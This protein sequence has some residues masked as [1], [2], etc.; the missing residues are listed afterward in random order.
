MAL[1][2]E[3]FDANASAQRYTPSGLYQTQISQ[4][5]LRLAI[6]PSTNQPFINGDAQVKTNLTDGAATINYCTLVPSG[7]NQPWNIQLNLFSGSNATQ[8]GWGYTPFTTGISWYFPGINP[9]QWFTPADKY[10]NIIAPEFVE[11]TNQGDNI[12]ALN[13]AT[14]DAGSA[15]YPFAGTTNANIVTVTPMLDMGFNNVTGSLGAWALADNTSDGGAAALTRTTV[16]PAEGTAMANIT[17]TWITGANGTGAYIGVIYTGNSFNGPINALNSIK[18]AVRNNNN[19]TT[20]PK[21]IVLQGT[22]STLSNY[23]VIG[24]GTITN[25]G[26]FHD[27]TVT[28]SP[29]SSDT[30]HG[31]IIAFYDT[32]SNVGKAWNI[33]VDDL[34]LNFKFAQLYNFAILKNSNYLLGNSKISALVT[35]NIAMKMYGHFDRLQNNYGGDWNFLA[36]K[37]Y[38]QFSVPTYPY[39]F[40]SS[41]ISGYYAAVLQYSWPTGGATFFGNT[42]PTSFTITNF[43]GSP[44]W[45]LNPTGQ[46]FALNRTDVT[47]NTYNWWKAS[48]TVV[49][50][51][52]FLSLIQSGFSYYSAPSIPTIQ[53]GFTSAYD[54]KFSFVSRP[55]VFNNKFNTSA[56]YK[57]GSNIIYQSS[58][59]KPYTMFT[60]QYSQIPIF[61]DNNVTGALPSLNICAISGGLQR[62]NVT[63]TGTLGSPAL[64]D[65]GV[66]TVIGGNSSTPIT[67]YISWDGSVGT[68]PLK[69][70]LKANSGGT[71]KTIDTG[72]WQDSVD[73][74]ID[75]TNTFTHVVGIKASGFNGQFLYYQMSGTTLLVSGEIINGA[76]LAG[77]PKPKIL[78]NPDGKVVVVTNQFMFRSGTNVWTQITGNTTTPLMVHA[79]HDVNYNWFVASNELTRFNQFI[80]TNGTLTP[81]V[82][83]SSAFSTTGQVSEYGAISGT[84]PDLPYVYY[85]GTNVII[86][87]NFEATAI[88]TQVFTQHGNTTGSVSSLDSVSGTRS[89]KIVTPAVTPTTGDYIQLNSS[90]G[91]KFISWVRIIQGQAYLA[92]GFYAGVQNASNIAAAGGIPFDV[93]IDANWQYIE[94]DIPS[95]AQVAIFPYGPS[96]CTL[97]IDN[98]KLLKPPQNQFDY[99]ATSGRFFI[100][101][102]SYYKRPSANLPT[103]WSTVTYDQEWNYMAQYE[104]AADSHGVYFLTD[105]PT[106]GTSLKLP[107]TTNSNYYD[108]T[109]G[110]STLYLNLR[111]GSNIWNPAFIWLQD[112]VTGSSPNMFSGLLSAQSRAEFLVTRD[113]KNYYTLQENSGLYNQIFNFPDESVNPPQ[114]AGYPGFID[115][116]T[117]ADPTKTNL[118]TKIRYYK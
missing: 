9:L 34:R 42:N 97:Y 78:V 92:T 37:T 17:K 81:F 55:T 19:A 60:N 87:N 111:S 90:S 38:H 35:S 52:P 47:N 48:G 7:L 8:R 30:Y 104:W 69:G 100:F 75:P 67:F 63:D 22:G 40:V 51:S 28:L 76:S 58:S 79:D 74:V 114:T 72:M 89:Y 49:D 1:F 96:G 10:T 82:L 64:V 85:D 77:I 106:G 43:G 5:T 102:P 71:I 110:F 101:V 20:T 3:T 88:N 27:V 16:T 61:G 103:N 84:A 65:A 14:G 80:S 39:D 70:T 73:A 32:S 86:D 94:K 108:A 4:N 36:V 56:L 13:F 57:S 115:P 26:S 31:L 116:A 107:I 45:L 12:N 99:M 15:N 91:G 113:N 11:F 54:Y 33:D 112:T 68:N 41:F 21:I 62:W 53:T 25:D 6:D 109:A 59:G 29:S 46:G 118:R 98:V 66:T 83:A 24:S 95:G 117:T 2:T 93:N 18:V 44:K 23:F 105:N 50:N